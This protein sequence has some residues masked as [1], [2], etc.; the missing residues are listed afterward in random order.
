MRRTWRGAAAALGA[1]ALAA[2]APAACEAEYGVDEQALLNED[3]PLDPSLVD[4][5]EDPFAPRAGGNA[6]APGAGPTDESGPQGVAHNPYDP[7]HFGQ[8]DDEDLAGIGGIGG[9][10]LYYCSCLEPGGFLPTVGFYACASNP[11]E[12][13]NFSATKAACILLGPGGC[14]AC[15][16]YPGLP[17][18]VKG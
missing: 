11:F 17:C 9:L 14:Q 13:A 12:A 10:S 16:C 8:G 1:L 4:E 7:E 5:G 6:F 18:L 2:L 15:V 3:N